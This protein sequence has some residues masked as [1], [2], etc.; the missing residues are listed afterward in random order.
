VANLRVNRDARK[1]ILVRHVRILHVQLP[2]A[3]PVF[4]PPIEFSESV[5]VVAALRVA[6]FTG[7]GFHHRGGRRRLA[8]SA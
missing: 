5:L 4:S 6:D 3:K 2:D 7:D 8:G 1:Q